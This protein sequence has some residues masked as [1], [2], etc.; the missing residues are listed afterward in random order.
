MVSDVRRGNEQRGAF[1]GH[2]VAN[3]TYFNHVNL[4]RKHLLCFLHT[5]MM[6]NCRRKPQKS[7]ASFSDC[8]STISNFNLF[9]TGPAT[10]SYCLHYEGRGLWG[11]SLRCEA[12]FYSPVIFIMDLP[13]WW[14]VFIN[15]ASQGLGVANG[16]SFFCRLLFSVSINSGRQLFLWSMAGMFKCVVCMYIHM[17]VSFLTILPSGSNGPLAFWSLNVC[18]TLWCSFGALQSAAGFDFF[19]TSHIAEFF[20]AAN[21]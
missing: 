15:A 19:S 1:G 21:L 13:I 16:Q 2:F 9:T 4:L 14:T 6:A 10:A 8:S 7:R 20:T 3:S 17:S 5:I 12:G 11:S 18:T